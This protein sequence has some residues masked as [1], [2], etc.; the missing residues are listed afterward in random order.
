M[1][2]RSSGL[3]GELW[4]RGAIGLLGGVI[5]LLF[6]FVV[7]LPLA[8]WNLLFVPLATASLAG[9]AAGAVV[10]MLVPETMFYGVQAAAYFIFGLFAV[11]FGQGGG[12]P[13]PASGTPKWLWA[14]FIFGAAYLLVLAVL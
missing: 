7:A 10:G 14:V 13:E 9:A 2:T 6:A 5:G 8:Y 11:M 1:R 3:A 4:Y 12:A